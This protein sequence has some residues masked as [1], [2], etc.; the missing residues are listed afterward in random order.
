MGRLGFVLV[1]VAASVLILDLVLS[2][3]SLA[4]GVLSL[5][6]VVYIGKI[7]YGLYLLHF[8]IY[9]F[10][11]Y[12][13]PETPFLLKG[14]LKFA[15]TF[16]VAAISYHL[17]EVRFLRLKRY[18]PTTAQVTKKS[19]IHK[20]VQATA[21]TAVPDLRRSPTEDGPATGTEER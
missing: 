10:V 6:G 15:V 2:P 8:P 9:S 14:P 19:G 12:V 20:E 3:F 17:V 7:S 13:V 4:K 11:D 18:S 5:P 21:T 1:A 16:L